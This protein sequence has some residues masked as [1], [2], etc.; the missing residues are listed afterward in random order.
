MQIDQEFDE[1][2]WDGN[3]VVTY[4]DIVESGKSASVIQ[5]TISQYVGRYNAR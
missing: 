5:S 4:N 3:G 2:D 1:D